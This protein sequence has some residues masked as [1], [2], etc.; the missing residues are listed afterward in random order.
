MTRTEDSRK[1]E[2]KRKHI[3]QAALKIFSSKGYDPTMIEEVAHE[4]GIAKGTLYLYFKDKEDLFYSTIMSVIED[5]AKIIDEKITRDMNP[6]EALR[7]LALI[8]LEYFSRNR[9]FF[10]IYLTILNYNLLSN[11]TRLFDSLIEKGGE[12][13]NFESALIERG[14]KEGLVRKD[15][16]TEDIVTSFQGIVSEMISH[17]YHNKKG[18]HSFDA[19]QKTKSI[20]KIFLKGVRML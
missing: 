13:F 16:I 5:L 12:L 7:K 19:E 18:G 15:V 4:A 14:K 1:K 11:Y 20:M 3:I 2:L 6:L 9:N 10:N 17:E 8:Q